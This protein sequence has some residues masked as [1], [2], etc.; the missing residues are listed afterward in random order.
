M[1]PTLS[2]AQ[3]ADLLGLHP[4][5]LLKELRLAGADK[6][7]VHAPLTDADAATLRAYYLQRYGDVPAGGFLFGPPATMPAFV[8][9]NAPEVTLLRHVFTR[10]W[11]AQPLTRYEEAVLAVVVGR[12][13]GRTAARTSLVRY[14]AAAIVT[15]TQV[16]YP[17]RAFMV[18]LSIKGEWLRRVAVLAKRAKAAL[19]SAVGA[20]RDA[21]RARSLHPAMAP[22]CAAV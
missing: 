5:A 20:C 22:P 8:R 15:H 3:F 17:L 9:G 18:R 16:A 10:D 2:I 11:T 4:Q 7:S 21:E 1:L 12:V 14:L 19:A 6:P 13:Y